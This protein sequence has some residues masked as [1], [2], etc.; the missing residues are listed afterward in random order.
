MIFTLFA[1]VV[2][3]LQAT[4][5][6]TRFNSHQSIFNEFSQ[7]K[8]VRYM[9]WMIV[10]VP[11]V[12]QF[13][14]LMVGAV[15][16]FACVAPVWFCAHEQYHFFDAQG[17]ARVKAAQSWLSDVEMFAVLVAAYIL[18]NLLIT[19]SSVVLSA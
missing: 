13:A 17:T 7:S 3:V 11:F 18:L 4:R 16:A 15:F 5:L 6:F 12:L 14:P 9:L 8:K 19:T 10:L 2:I 1:L